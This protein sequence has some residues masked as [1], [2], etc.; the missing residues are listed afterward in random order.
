[1]ALAVQAN[2]VALKVAWSRRAGVD[3]DLHPIH[4]PPPGVVRRF[5]EVLID[6]ALLNEYS[7]SDLVLRTRQVWGEFSLLCWAFHIRDAQQPPDFAALAPGN[8]F[9]CPGALVDREQ[10]IARR[11]WRLQHEQRFRLDRDARSDPA[12]QRDHEYAQSIR[13]TVDDQ[14]IRLVPPDALLAAACEHAGMLGAIR[15]LIDDRRVW[16]EPGIMRLGEI[17]GT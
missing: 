11:L 5:R 4:A 12:F 6:R 3:S 7:D 2:L 17:S 15:W 16:N 1:M 10:E 13:M 8:P 14:D 9:R